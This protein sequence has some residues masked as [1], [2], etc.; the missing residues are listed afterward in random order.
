MENSQQGILQYFLP[1]GSEE[2]GN[3]EITFY[4]MTMADIKQ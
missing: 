3:T 4:L 2:Y 1:S